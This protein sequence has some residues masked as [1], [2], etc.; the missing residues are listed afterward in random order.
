MRIPF[1]EMQQEFTRVLLQE[2]FAPE[3]AVHCARLFAETSLDGVYSHGLNRFPEFIRYI[4]QG[5]VDVQASPEKVEGLGL[6]ERWDGRLGPGNLNAWHCMGR[7]IALATANGMGCVALRNT[8]HWMRGGTYGWQAAEAGCIAI[9]FTNTKPN[10][11]AWGGKDRRI[12]NNP[13]VVA[14]P[15]P[16]GHIVL[17]M[18]LSQYSFGK[19]E[20]YSLQGKQLP[21]AGGYDQQGELTHDPAEILQTRRALP[22]GLWKGSGLAIMLD[23]LATLLSAGRSTAEVGHLG[24]EYGVSQLFI[25]FDVRRLQGE[26]VLHQAANDIIR[27]VRQAAP[28]SPGQKVYY[29]GERTL[30]TR[31][32]N[33]RLGIPVIPSVWQQVREM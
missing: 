28:A 25:C 1:S 22:I 11:P 2:G 31:Q 5:Y 26:G 14:V 30:Q 29:P 21:F 16:E 8:N 32:E 27:F 9:C 13:L 20:D 3:R 15:R 18:A 17:D 12:G 10:M 23:L 33:L 6:L 24:D 19:L 7:T 4:R